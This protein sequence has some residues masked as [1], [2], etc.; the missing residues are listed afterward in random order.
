MNE[1]NLTFNRYHVKNKVIDKV[2]SVSS[3]EAA[4]F[5]SHDPTFLYCGTADHR[6]LM[7]VS[8]LIY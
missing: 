4:S 5:A 7:N 3:F 2:G 1:P 8:Q 6:V